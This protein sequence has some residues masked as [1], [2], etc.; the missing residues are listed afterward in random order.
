MR[1]RPLQVMV[2]AMLAV[3]GC[4]RQPTA[5]PVISGAQAFGLCLAC[6]SA[7]AENRP[8]GPNL[9]GLIGRTAGTRQGFFYSEPLKT[10]GIVWSA[11]TLD[12][13]LT[14]PSAMVPGTF[15][16]AT[17]PDARQRAAVVQYLQGLK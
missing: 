7:A 1:I 14:N 8:T 15:M 16:M 17:V 12:R 6:H 9:H 11:E 5:G 10:S 13:F 3:A 4:S 2:L